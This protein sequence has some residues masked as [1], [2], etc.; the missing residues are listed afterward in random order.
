MGNDRRF[1]FKKDVL[2]SLEKIYD[3]VA[4][5]DDIAK[6]GV[7]VL[8]YSGSDEVLKN[9]LKKGLQIVYNTA[10]KNKN[11]EVYYDGKLQ[12]SVSPVQFAPGWEIFIKKDDINYY[13]K[14]YGLTEIK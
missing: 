4:S 13:L 8:G 2:A 1:I 12:G 14:K 10:D 9:W 11:F 5:L 3:T 6:I 7:G